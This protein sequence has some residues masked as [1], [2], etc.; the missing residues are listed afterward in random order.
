MQTTSSWKFVQITAKKSSKFKKISHVDYM[1]LYN[2]VKYLVQTRLRLW[3]IKI[4]KIS[5]VW[6]KYFTKL[7]IIISSIC[8][9]FLVNL[10]DFF[11]HSLHEFSRTCDLHKICSYLEGISL[12][13]FH[14]VQGPTI[15]QHAWAARP[16][17]CA[18]FSF[19]KIPFPLFCFFVFQSS[20]LNL[21][22]YYK[23]T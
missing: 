20:S 16:G 2:L 17:R 7:C 13:N 14:I 3:D 22:Y 10:D 6:T 4:S 15:A 5:E 21:L 8:V 1:M 18:P 11:C 9:I 12:T 23:N 19:F